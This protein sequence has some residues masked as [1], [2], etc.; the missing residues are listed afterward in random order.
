MIDNLADAQS[1]LVD[2]IAMQGLAG[3]AQAEAADTLQ[4][5][6]ASLKSAWENQLNLIGEKLAPAI[7]NLINIVASLVEN[8]NT[9]GPIVAGLAVTFGV[10]AV[11]INIGGIIKSVTTAFAA[12]NAIL[13]A[14]PIGIVV[15]AI[16]GLVTAIVLLWKNNEEFRN[17]VTAAW[18]AVKNAAIGLK[19][20]I[21]NAFNA[22]KNTIAGIVKSAWTWGKDLLDNFIGGIKSKIGALV[23]SVRGVAGKVRSFLGFSEPDEGPLSNFHTYAPDMM[24]L[25]AQGIKEN[26][27]LIT[28]QIGKSFDFGSDI[29]NIGLTGNGMANSGT[30]NTFGAVSISIYPKEGQNADDIAE[31]VMERIQAATN[32][33]AAA[34]T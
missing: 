29:A 23:D 14:N 34:L 7:K 21:V 25:F 15:A 2:Y 32:R 22:V 20:G 16:A 5:S 1:A 18:N 33:R 19:D 3:Y 27:H 13:L 9:V 8:F 26:E 31:A 12:F 30:T 28:D 24:K 11:A 17:K 4:G 6:L 10:F